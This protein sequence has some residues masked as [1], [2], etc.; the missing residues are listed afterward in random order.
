M[1]VLGHPKL[2]ASGYRL[3]ASGYR[4]RGWPSLKCRQRIIKAAAYERPALAT[5]TPTMSVHFP[6][7]LV[8]KPALAAGAADTR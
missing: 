3:Q 8:S 4:Y 7:Q 1:L 6:T 2:L 5:N